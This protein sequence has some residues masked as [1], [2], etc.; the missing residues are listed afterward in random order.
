MTTLITGGA[1]FIGSYL[2]QL[3][4]EEGERPI[5]LD[6]APVH[7]ALIDIRDR[8]EYV[9]SSLG[10]LSVVLNVIKK[11]SI[12][13]IFHLGGMLSAPSDENP[14]AAFDANVTGTYNVLE[15]ARLGGVKQ[16]I[17]SS[18]IAVYGKDLPSTPVDD[19]TIQRP[20]SM[21]GS[22]KV[23]CELLGRFYARK[24]DLDFRGVRIPSVVGP[25]AKT[26]HMSIYN[27]WAI[28]E[29]LKGQPYKLLCEPETRCPVI[30]F[31]D[32]GRALWLLAMAERSQIKTRIYN[33]A[34]I[35]PSFSAEELV[36]LIRDR[37]P[38]ARLTFN[39]DPATVE[40]LK[41][42][43]SLILDDEC[44]RS[45]WGWEIA[46]PLEEMVDDF[47]KEFEEHTSWYV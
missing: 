6:P 27:C 17:F 21:Y 36:A 45:E 5:L 19:A 40:L 44:A 33:L 2:T 3:L 29:A 42:L 22:T 31:K 12:D 28:E 10:N 11:Y 16:V 39:P 18:T 25:G 23:F 47:I 38:E 15:A 1:G 24:F 41:E 9:Q 34:G 13:R 37:I 26:A 30:Y 32:A 8:F 46:Y 4:I 7:G 43:G 20:T 14:W 35:V